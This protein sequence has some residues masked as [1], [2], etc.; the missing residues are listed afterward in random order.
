M[1]RPSAVA[2]V[3]VAATLA[4]CQAGGPGRAPGPSPAACAEAAFAGAPRLELQPPEGGGEGVSKSLVFASAIPVDAGIGDVGRWRAVTPGWQAWRLRLRAAGADS[5]SVH[6]SPLSLP[7]QAELWICAP[8]GA[9][10]GP[11]GGL[12]PAGKGQHWSAPVPGE[13]LWLEVL[14]PDGEVSE[15]RLAIAT[16]FAG[17]R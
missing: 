16:G 11:I 1:R 10:Q 6:L 5:L 12:G 15:A 4:A 9:R 17:R 8:G 3:L 2:A 13:E 14:A 7:A